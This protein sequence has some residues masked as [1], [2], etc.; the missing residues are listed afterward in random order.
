[1]KYA[2]KI[3]SLLL[4]ATGPVALL[5]GATSFWW[6]GAVFGKGFAPG[7]VA[8]CFFLLFKAFSIGAVTI[9]PLFTAMGYVKQTS[10]IL[11]LS[12]ILYLGMAWQLGRTVGLLGLALAYGVQASTV[13]GLKA[14]Y[15]RQRGLR[16]SAAASP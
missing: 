4:A 8:L 9:H 15:I 6:L 12:D 13:V 5:V 3:G 2:V 1:V 16:L 7:A 14:F 10:F 11:F